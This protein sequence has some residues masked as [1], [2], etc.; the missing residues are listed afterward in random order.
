MSAGLVRVQLEG[1][2]RNK[3]LPQVFGKDSGDRCT[4]ANSLLSL[5]RAEKEFSPFDTPSSAALSL[6]S[7]YLSY[8][9]R[10]VTLSASIVLSRQAGTQTRLFQEVAIHTILS[11][12]STIGLLAHADHKRVSQFARCLPV[13][14]PLKQLGLKSLGT[15]NNFMIF[16][17]VPG[18]AVN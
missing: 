1:D 3:I 8:A 9:R 7:P 15:K 4:Q 14:D 17:N 11:R 2:S 18:L 16:S 12:F 10:K 5:K 6:M 13:P